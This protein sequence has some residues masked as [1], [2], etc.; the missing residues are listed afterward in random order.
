MKKRIL[1]VK[2]LC[3]LALCLL[4]VAGTASPARAAAI[5]QDRTPIFSGDARLDY[6]AG[7]ILNSI[8]MDGMTDTQKIAAVYDWIIRN[9]D[10]EG[11]TG[12]THFDVNYLD[13]HADEWAAL[14]DDLYHQGKIRRHYDW[15]VNPLAYEMAIYRVGSCAHFASLLNVLIERLG[16][17]CYLVA[18]DFVN[19]DGS[20]VEHK[21]NIVL[22]DDQFYWL[23]VRMDHAGYMRTGSVPHTYF[24]K[25]DTAAWAKKHV[26]DQEGYDL[27]IEIS[28]TQAEYQR[29]AAGTAGVAK[30][31]ACYLLVDGDGITL[32][33]FTINGNNYFKLRDIA[34]LFEETD[35]P[36]GFSVGYDETSST[37][38]ITR[39]G[40]YSRVG[41]EYLGTGLRVRA[42]T[43]TTTP[44]LVDG[45]PVQLSVYQIFGSNYFKLRDL[46]SLLD[47]GVDWDESTQTIILTTR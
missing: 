27:D 22:L 16:Y 29:I 31:R 34:A 17:E 6:M 32:N 24:M 25:T 8:P 35:S 15:Y 23:D 26:W 10:R 4:L 41:G 47:F 3:S 9:C 11:S 40:S 45:Q 7:V 37:V 44:V 5:V 46:G 38:S 20:R 12:E 39:G 36:C 21:W 13:A 43:P 14:Y 18:G 2:R 19:N 30:P 28:T 42:C 1:S 33:A